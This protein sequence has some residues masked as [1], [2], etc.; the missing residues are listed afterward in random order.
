MGKKVKPK[1]FYYNLFPKSRRG[2][3]IGLF[4]SFIIF[5]VFLTFLYSTMEPIIKV[6]DDKR[7]ILEYL[8]TALIEKLNTNLTTLTIII[9][10]SVSQDCVVLSSLIEEDKGLN[11]KIIVKDY[12]KNI[13]PSYISDANSNDLIVNRES[14]NYTFFKVY[15]SEEFES[16]NEM[17]IGE[18]SV[19]TNDYQIRLLKSSKYI[20]KTKVKELK[21]GYLEEYEDIKEELNIPEDS[22]FGFGFIYHNGTVIETESKN[23]SRSV[24]VNE[25]PVRYIDDEA[26]IL[27]GYIKI[28]IW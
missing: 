12:D 25:V 14:S 23:V 28:K 7:F 20:S 16:L 5:V 19:L 11:S 24:Y 3:H 18:C 8:E 2:S 10:E 15:G 21:E 22:D 4:L 6:Q 17:P 13:V 26:N 1:I 9:N 27:S